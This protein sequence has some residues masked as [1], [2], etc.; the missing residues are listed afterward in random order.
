MN[1][2]QAPLLFSCPPNL[3]VN[4][5]PGVCYY[6]GVLPKP[7]AT[8]NCPVAPTIFCFLVTPNQSIPITPQTQFPKGDNTITCYAEDA[9]G[10]QSQSCSFIVTV[11]DMEP[12][13]I[14]CPMNTSISATGCPVA[15]YNLQPTN[16][17]DNCGVAGVSAVVTGATSWFGQNDASGALFNPGVS[18]VVYTVTDICGNSTSCSFSVTVVCGPGSPPNLCGQ[19]ALTCFS[20]FN[21]PYNWQSGQKPNGVVLALVDPRALTNVPANGMDASNPG[22]F[23]PSVGMVKD[24]QWVYSRMGQVFGLA[25]DA[26]DFVYATASTIYGKFFDPFNNNV[27]FGPAGAGGIYKINPT[28]GAV[29]DFVSTTL[30]PNP[31]NTNFIYNTGSGLGN[32]CYDKTHNQFFVTNFTDGKIYRIDINGI[33]QSIYDHP[34]SQTFPPTDPTYIPLGDRPYGIQ[35]HPQN[36]RLYYNVWQ[37]D[38][39]R[40][41]NTVS[42]E[43]WSIALTGAGDFSGAATPVLQIPPV[44]GKIY[45]NAPS[46][47]A[48]SQSGKM[49]IGER[50]TNRDWPDP[51][52]FGNPAHDSRVLEYCCDPAWGSPTT[53]Y[54]G[55]FSANTNCA[56]GMDYGYAGF[57]FIQDKPTDCDELIW[58]TGDALKYTFGFNPYPG[59]NEVVYGLAGL[60]A[61][62]P[63]N[64]NVPN[65]SNWVKTTS[66]Y[67]DMGLP[68]KTEFGDVE[69]FKC[70][71]P[72]NPDFPCDSL[73][74][75]KTQPDTSKCCFNMTLD[76]HAGPVA[77]IEAESLTPGVVFNNVT[78]N[79]TFAWT[80]NPNPNGTLL[81][82][83]HNPFQGIPQGTYPNALKFCL[84]N[85]MTPSQVPQ[86]VVFRWYVKGPDDK[87]YLACTDTCYFECPL[88]VL[89]DTC[90]VVK[91]DSIYCDPANP[92]EYC[93]FLTVENTSTDLTFI[94]NQLIMSGLTPGFSF[95]PCPPPNISFTAPSIALNLI[96]AIAPGSTSNQLCVKLVAL[97]PVLTP[98]IVCMNLGLSGSNDCCN[99]TT[100]FCVTL[101]PCCDPCEENDVVVHTANTDSCC[102][103]LD[104]TNNCNYNFFTSLELELLTPGVSFGSHFIGG[105]SPADWNNPVSLYNLIQWQ[106]V[107]GYVPNGTIAGLINFCIDGID[108]PSEIPQTVVLHWIIPGSN[109]QDSSACSDTL[110]FECPQQDFPCIQVLEDTIRCL[111][112]ANGNT[113]YEYTM[114]FQNTSSPQHTADELIFTQIGVPPVLVFPS[115]VPLVPPLLPNGITTITTNIFG[116]GLNPGDKLT[117]EVRLHDSTDPDD[118]CCFEGD[119]LCIFIPP[120]D[121]CKCGTYSDMSY[122]PV[123][124]APNFPAV[125]GDTLFAQ[126][127]GLIPWTFSGNFLCMGAICP[128]QTPMFWT[129]TGPTGC[130]RKAAVWGLHLVSVFRCRLR[131]SHKRACTT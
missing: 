96:P 30:N 25:I 66:Y 90:V 51:Q 128:P 53:F 102:Y 27:T 86:C 97:A 47:L 31:V 115:S 41:S 4:T 109:G 43:V 36:G 67:I 39:G 59:D 121:T 44:P 92:K 106:H 16:I 129:L 73:W 72:N 95:K 75:T 38:L 103:E 120:C 68:G 117:F 119:T 99:S 98:T 57:D 23:L 60:P 49:L 74:V 116:S 11:R 21:N 15:V 6:T 63:G 78:L 32:I 56:G 85:I 125:C 17:A 46:D 104:I 22:N 126:C 111:K 112:D 3:S 2:S 29:T 100:P 79:S 18:T 130:L 110:V 45:S 1:D 122:R 108:D 26:N 35:V 76:V 81:S 101:E 24:P 80:G 105:P 55:N 13:T 58:S 118:W 52:F 33:V 113:Y 14:T 64:S 93:L 48:F 91:T 84:G 127:Q 89:G 65:S 37:E 83:K 94:A 40:P 77:Y 20:G 61:P 42:N 114:T 71:C 8:D 5:N 50:T 12:P 87:P 124:G 9:C 62:P 88:P 131:I 54:V 34:G 123:Q 7:T 28:T 82:F 107:S 10:N 70:E 19:A 69:V